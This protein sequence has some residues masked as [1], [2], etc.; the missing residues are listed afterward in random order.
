MKKI[1]NI[2]VV[3]LVLLTVI[4]MGNVAGTYAKYT[5]T[6]TGTTD[7][8]TVAKWAFEINDQA[9]TNTFTFDLFKTINEADGTTTEGDVAATKIAPGTGGKF[10]IKLANKSEVNA[11]YSV[12]Y[13]ITNEAGI[14][15]EF[16]IDKGATWTTGLTNVSATA[17]N[18]NANTTI[19]IQW[20]WAFEGKDSANYTSTQTDTTD[21]D[22]GKAA[23]A[24]ITVKAD[25][26]ATQVD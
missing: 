6:F 25:I 1:R 12:A 20:R 23:S 18:Q 21:T 8:A 2:F 3:T 16:S 14:P 17:I 10:S 26:T 19:E 11:K 13:T 15:V 5:S 9:A 7:T 22:L 24:S 4:S